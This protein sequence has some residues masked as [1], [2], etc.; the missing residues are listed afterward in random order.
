MAIGLSFVFLI[1]GLLIGSK[2]KDNNKNDSPVI[3]ASST[4]FAPVHDETHDPLWPQ[5]KEVAEHFLC[6]CME[7]GDMQLA[8]CTCGMSNGGIAEKQFIRSQ[9]VQ[10]LEKDEV[11]ALVQN[12]FGRRIP[13]TAELS[14]SDLINKISS[15]K[16]FSSD[17]GE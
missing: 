16:T 13:T 6:G 8:Q 14:T 4:A 3:A 7:C 12:K 15:G 10:G 1:T 2:I 5:I 11:I 9:L 17:T